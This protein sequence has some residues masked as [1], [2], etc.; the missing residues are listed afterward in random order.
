[1]TVT[2]D[3]DLSGPVGDRAFKLVWSSD[4][5]DPAD[6]KLLFY[7]YQDGRQVARTQ[8]TEWMFHVE[9]GASSRIEIFDTDPEASGAGGISDAW[10]GRMHLAWKNVEGATSYRVEEFVASVWTARRTIADDGNKPN[11]G[12]IS[13]F[14]EDVTIHQFRVIPIA[15]NGLEGTARTFSALMVRHPDQ[16]VTTKTYNGSGTPTV[17]IAAA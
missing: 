1:M 10:P 3:N 17:T 4:Q 6:D 2:I 11:F 16:P 14:L 13:R 8:A 7:V 12:F 15:A 5:A 9:Q